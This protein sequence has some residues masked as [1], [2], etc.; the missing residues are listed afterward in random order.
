MIWVVALALGLCARASASIAA[1]PAP[2]PAAAARTGSAP[3]VRAARPTTV[4]ELGTG[5]GT[6][7]CSPVHDSTTQCLG[8]PFA[9]APT[10]VCC[11]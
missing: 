4:V 1:V 3:R 6:L 2:A 9:A 8:I 5:K 10:K 11:C 7:R